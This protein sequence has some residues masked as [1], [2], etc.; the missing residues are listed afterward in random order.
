MSNQGQDPHPITRYYKLCNPGTGRGSKA[1]S[2][3]ARG[4]ANAECDIGDR[5]EG[6]A[7]AVSSGKVRFDEHR[8]KISEIDVANDRPGARMGGM[9]AIIN[10]QY[11][12]TWKRSLWSAYSAGT[13]L[14]PLSPFL[15]QS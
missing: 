15:T 11:L 7:R 4:N 9:H 10:I 2:E 12:F 8:D 13:V 6:F 14:T 3:I 1:R 5:N